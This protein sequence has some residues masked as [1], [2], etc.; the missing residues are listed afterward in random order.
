MLAALLLKKKSVAAGS[1]RYVKL[2]HLTC[3]TTQYN[4]VTISELQIIDSSSGTNWC[5]QSGVVASA[6]SYYHDGVNPD[7][8][9]AQAIDGYID[10]SVGHRWTS[11]PNANATNFTLTP[12]WFMVDFGQPRA[13]NSVQLAVIDGYGQDP[14]HFTIEGSND[15]VNFTVIK[16]VI[17][18]GYST[19]V[20]TEVLKT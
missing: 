3:Q 4:C 9:P 1:Y 13:F 11:A 18:S 5:R 17:R 7:Q 19:N 15:N 10:T 12:I 20:L 2:N 6:Y 14:V 16:E 8:L